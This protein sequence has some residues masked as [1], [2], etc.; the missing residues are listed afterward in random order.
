MS[1]H[2]CTHAGCPYV[3]HSKSSLAAHARTHT[4]E[5][6]YVCLVPGCSFA[7][8][9]NSNLIAHGRRHSALRPHACQAEG[10]VYAAKSQADLRGHTRAVHHTGPTLSC[11]WEACNFK[12]AN[13]RVLRE[14]C[15]THTGERPYTCVKCGVFTS[16]FKG[17]MLQHS[18]RCGEGARRRGGAEDAGD[19]EEFTLDS[20]QARLGDAAVETRR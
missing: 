13:A 4:G 1:S 8:I 17:H 19:L 12:A 2:V 10:C 15:H 20:L 14:H 6:P 7:A 5:R 11:P 3:A 9:S 16:A 18:K